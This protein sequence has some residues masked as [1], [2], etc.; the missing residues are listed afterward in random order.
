[1]RKIKTFLLSPTYVYYRVFVV[2]F[3]VVVLIFLDNMGF[4][5]PTIWRQTNDV[6]LWVVGILTFYPLIFDMLT[7]IY[8]LIRTGF[9]LPTKENYINKG[10]YIL[11][12]T[13]KW[14]VSNGGFTKAQLHSWQGSTERYA[15]DFA[16]FEDD[17]TVSGDWTLPTKVE[18]YPCYGKDISEARRCYCQVRKL[19]NFYCAPYSFSASV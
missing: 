19:W 5:V 1:M 17:D 11:P 3:S 10:D 8:S 18:Q 12:F 2:V 4:E 15:Y 6:A 13:G 14:T 7:M 9:R 16:I